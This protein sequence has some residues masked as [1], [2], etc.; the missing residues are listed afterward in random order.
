MKSD[1]FIINTYKHLFDLVIASFKNGKN[2]A[3]CIDT[4]NNAWFS[5]NF[6]SIFFNLYSIPELAK[7]VFGELEHWCNEIGFTYF[8]IGMN[9]TMHQFIIT[10]TQE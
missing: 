6:V 1:Y 7:F 8:A 10:R 2:N 5:Y 4:S 9:N 3:M